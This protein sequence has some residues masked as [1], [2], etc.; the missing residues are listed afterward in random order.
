M[1]IRDRL[2]TPNQGMFRVALEDTEVD[3][4]AI[5][6]GSR[7]WVIFGAANRDLAHFDDGEDF[8]PGRDNL[9][10]HVAFGKGHHFCI[11]APL[12]R[13]E[14]KVAFEELTRY[15]ECPA[16]SPSNTFEYEPSFVLRGLAKLD[17]DIKKR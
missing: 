5:P 16:F 15:L 13:L 2:S 7:L 11:G 10:D 14:G 9:K 12:S 3:G 6:K 8:D 4:V 17:L 1:C